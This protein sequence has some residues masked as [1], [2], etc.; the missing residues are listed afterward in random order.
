[1]GVVMGSFRRAYTH[2]AMRQVTWLRLLGSL[3]VAIGVLASACGG[4]TTPGAVHVLRA[5]NDVGP[6]MDDYIDRGIARAEDNDA[7]A[8]VIEL[9]TPGGLDSSMR[10]IVKRIERATVPIV[11]YVSP[12]GGRAASAGTFITMAA[13]IAAM[14]PNTSI[15][16]ASAVNSDGTDIGGTLGKKV[17]ND[18][19]SFIRG[20]AELRGRNAD[21]AEQAVR[22][23]ASASQ[24]QAVQLRVVDFE[25]ENLAALLARID[26][27]ETKTGAGQ[28]VRLE[29]LVAAPIVYTN[30]TFWERLLD[31]LA[32]PTV[33]SL[34][35]TL[36]FLGL[37]FELGNPGLV[38]PGVCGAIALVLGFLGLGTLPVHTVGLILIGLAL[39]FFALEIAL[40]S[41]F[42]G[43]GG[44]V[45]LILGFIVTF[46]D[47]PASVRPPT[48]LLVALGILFAAVF[49]S[50]LVM[51]IRVRRQ[52][53]PLAGTAALVGRL[54]VARTA[55]APEGFVF[56]EGERWR[57]RLDDG[58]ADE[59]ERV[60]ITGFEGLRLRVRK[61]DKA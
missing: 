38:F 7:K 30:M 9:D 4:E 8:V 28:P 56:I 54:A 52:G 5:D 25:S 35:I 41:G 21:W 3:A 13:N 61:E 15:G 10:A 12:A 19:V 29:G 53:A 51:V 23:A 17:E 58:S 47:T 1:M 14:A 50:I 24:S 20:I 49:V 55:L 40:P 59:G 45:A 34:L 11:V 18:A 37:V 6:I 48:V 32:D 26:G 2:N 27:V 36:G 44:V 39:L 43:A 22:E 60:R 31:F 57:A 33:A 16:A 46:R 42:L